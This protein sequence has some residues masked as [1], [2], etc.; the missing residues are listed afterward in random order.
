[1]EDQDKQSKKLRTI[2][3]VLKRVKWDSRFDPDDFIIGYE[4]WTHLLPE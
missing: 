2:E 4:G 1:M 3:D